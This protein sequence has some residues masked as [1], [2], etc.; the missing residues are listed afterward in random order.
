MENVF[1]SND[2]FILL[3]LGNIVLMY[4]YTLSRVDLPKFNSA[5]KQTGYKIRAIKTETT[6]RK[7]KIQLFK[8]INLLFT[9]KLIKKIK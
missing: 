7:K 4:R 2:F 5:A 3:R 6:K 9:Y 8:K 1:Q